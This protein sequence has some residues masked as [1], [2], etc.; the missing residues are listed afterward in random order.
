MPGNWKKK[1]SSSAIYRDSC[2]DCRLFGQTRLKGRAAFSDLLPVGEVK[3]EIRHGVAIT[4]LSHSSLNPFNM[5]LVVEGTY[6]LKHTV[7]KKPLDLQNN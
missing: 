6:W 2:G 3:T 7:W 4:S 1:K 5:E